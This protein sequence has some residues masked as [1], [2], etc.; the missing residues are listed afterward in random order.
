MNFSTPSPAK[1]RVRIGAQLTVQFLKIYRLIESI[2]QP[3]DGGR[4]IWI[5]SVMVF[6]G[7]GGDWL[8]YL[9]KS[10]STEASQTSLRLNWISGVRSRHLTA[11]TVEIL[12]CVCFYSF[13]WIRVTFRM[14]IHHT[15]AYEAFMEHA[16]LMC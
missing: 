7:G 4:G 14:V 9:E 8:K 11:C 12:V 10:L 5:L 2:A 13:L 15:Y 1:G 16:G 3:T 6:G